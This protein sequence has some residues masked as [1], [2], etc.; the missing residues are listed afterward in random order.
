[1]KRKNIWLA[2]TSVI[3]VLICCEAILRLL[4]YQ[5]GTFRKGQG[6]KLV[7]P[8]IVYRNFTTDEAGIYKFSPWVSDSFPLY[9][10]CQKGRITSPVI[11]QN[12]SPVDDLDYIYESFCRV[13]DPAAAN[14]PVWEIRRW[15]QDGPDTSEFVSAY[16]RALLQKDDTS[17]DWAIAFIN[18]VHHPFDQEGFRSI[19]FKRY[20]SKRKKVLLIG[21][22]FVYGMSAHP[23]Y[24]CFADILLAR[25]YLVYSAGIPGTDP[26]QYAA[27]AQKYVPLL[28]PD[29]VLVCFYEGNDYMPFPRIPAADQP[30]EHITNAGFF[31]SSPLGVYLNPQQAYQYAASLALIPETSTNSFNRLCSHSALT[32]ILWG[33]LYKMNF[34][35]HPAATFADSILTHPGIDTA[36]TAGRM[37]LI[38][39]VCRASQIPLKVVIIPNPDARDNPKRPY[40]IINKTL[41]NNVMGSTGYSTPKNLNKKTDFPTGDYHFNN[42]GSEKFADYLDS[43][44]R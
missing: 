30:H 35:K 39:S 7:D 6:F 12:L 13:Q 36:F 20:K 32:G 26:A 40:L 1:M 8:L 11:D 18:Y 9:F 19:A 41:A 17:D 14:T 15:F 31:E 33:V 23:R 22:S 21:D 4:G 44:L 16:H 43:L 42:R 37:Q 2:F 29:I 25:G 24:N 38:D 27:I 3:L 34:V 5:P 10:D 28:K